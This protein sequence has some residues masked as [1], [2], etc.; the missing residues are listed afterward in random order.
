MKAKEVRELTDAELSKHIA[1]CRR[2]L[3]NCRIQQKIGQLENSARMRKLKRDI[4]RALTEQNVRN[5][6]ATA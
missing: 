3:F 2:E 5:N 4:A 6:K 1:D